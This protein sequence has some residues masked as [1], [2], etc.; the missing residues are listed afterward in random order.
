MR[1]S[2]IVITLGMMLLAGVVARADKVTSDYDHEVNFSQYKTFMWIQR[3]KCEEPF[4]AER[5]VSA[6]NAQ[7]KVKGLSEVTEGADMAVGAN[8]ATE[9][10]HEWETYYSGSG[11]GWD[12]GWSTTKVKTYEVGT[13]TVDLFDAKRKKLAWQGVAIDELSPHPRK[14]DR[15]IGKEIEKMFKVF[16]PGTAE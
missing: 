6:I 4:M 5:I 12:G 11:W 9:E 7:L 3:P 15:E 14:R 13:L 1:P 16:P 10:Q 8:F 2:G